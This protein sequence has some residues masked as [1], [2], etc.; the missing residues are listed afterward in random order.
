MLK[1]F[2]LPPMRLINVKAFWVSILLY[3]LLLDYLYGNILAPLFSYMNFVY[4]PTY[5][6]ICISWGLLIITTLLILPILCKDGVFVRNYV[7]LIFLMRFVPLTV[8]IKSIPQPDGFVISQTVFWILHFLFL[9]NVKVP[10]L[11]KHESPLVFYIISILMVLSVLYVSG[12]YTG[13]RIDTN[14]FKLDFSEVY[15]QRAEARLYHMPLLIL[16]LRMASTNAIPVIMI[17]F[18]ENKKYAIT[19]FLLIIVFLNF[20]IDGTKT[21]FFKLLLCFFIYFFIK[22]DILKKML[23]AF[24]LLVLLSILEYI[25]LGTEILTY[26]LIRRAFFVPAILDTFYYDFI[27]EKGLLFFSHQYNGQDIAFVIGDTYF[28]KDEMRANNG[29]FSD[30]FMNLG[31][32]GCILYPI[33][34]TYFLK[35]SENAM[36]GSNQTIMLYASLIYVWNMMS[37][38]FTT[39]LMTHGLLLLTLT[40]YFLPNKRIREIS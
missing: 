10:I 31:Y 18:M 16:Y 30:A 39:T 33:I 6:S 36:R 13:F 26:V 24:I 32:F 14:F 8:V 7:L 5:T 23:L 4:E 20:S 9:R 35:I 25:F 17:Y 15:E 34:Y 11:K 21:T 28:S 22:G 38:E 19:I 1:E 37:S 2:S 3:R 29:M 40:F 12:I 27:Q